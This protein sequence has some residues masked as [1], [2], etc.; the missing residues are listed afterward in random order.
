M[1][2]ASSPQARS[3]PSSPDRKAAEVCGATA[4]ARAVGSGP[5]PLCSQSLAMIG[6][7]WEPQEGTVALIRHLWARKGLGALHCSLIPVASDS[8]VLIPLFLR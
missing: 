1:S 8:W 3:A 5:F 7:V 2:R 4:Q 6:E